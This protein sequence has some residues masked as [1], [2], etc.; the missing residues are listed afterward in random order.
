MTADVCVAAL[1]VASDKNKLRLAA[2]RRFFL[3]A[4]LEQALHR[5]Q[6]MLRANEL[7]AILG[8]ERATPAAVATTGTAGQVFLQNHGVG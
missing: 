2:R 8:A 1:S 5:L 3:A 6:Y 7:D 4:A